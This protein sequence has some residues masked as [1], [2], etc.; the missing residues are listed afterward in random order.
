MASEDNNKPLR[1]K[2]YQTDQMN[3]AGYITGVL[4]IAPE[5]FGRDGPRGRFR[6]IYPFSVEE[7]KRY[8]AQYSTSEAK[9]YDD[10]ILFFKRNTFGSKLG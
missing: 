9:A 5:T 6:A 4:K 7:G 8:E 1:I 10:A 2:K 3:V